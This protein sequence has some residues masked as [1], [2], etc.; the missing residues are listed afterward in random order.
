MGEGP[1]ADWKRGVEKGAPLRRS[2]SAGTGIVAA[3]VLL[4]GALLLF[5]LPAFDRLPASR[6]DARPAATPVSLRV[7][8]GAETGVAAGKG[9][10]AGSKRPSPLNDSLAGSGPAPGGTSAGPELEPVQ[11]LWERPMAGVIALALAP[12]GSTVAALSAP[13]SSASEPVSGPSL[14]A[15]DALGVRL[16]V[17][18]RDSLLRWE[19]WVEE[20]SHVVVG[21]G[22]EL[23][24]TYEPRSALFRTLHFWS[25][26]GRPEG[27]WRFEEALASIAIDDGNR[28]VA[29]GALDGEVSLLHRERSGWRRGSVWRVDPP[30][31]YVAF[32]PGE[33]LWVL[34]G[35]PPT[36]ARC[37]ADG[38]PLWQARVWD[39]PAR[40]LGFS[41][42]GDGQRAAVAGEVE[43]A[44]GAQVQLWSAEGQRR[45]QVTL[46][47][48]APH[49][50]LTESGLVVGYER[51]L[52]RRDRGRLHTERVIG[53]YDAGGV[54]RWRKGGAFFAPLLIAVEARGDWVLSLGDESK[55]WLLGRDGETRWRSV[56]HPPVQVAVGSRNG[57]SAA[58]YRVDGR[59]MLLALGN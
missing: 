24:V 9:S 36:L 59:L 42:S 28:R 20:C 52:P 37:S 29:A 58:A 14:A 53:A 22:G 33:S 44:G 1:R 38:R 3:L 11:L 6:S 39:R 54:E 16:R 34:A 50:R 57:R 7:R 51:V 13:G 43:G 30:V 40:N 17:Y 4:I 19:R 27:A 26:T 5:G 8:A 23:I 12:E 31:H 18:G 47:G 45:W 35:L 25:G 46:K 49:V 10:V 21:R 48:R 55:F 15:Q 41:T 56:R 32:G 2:R